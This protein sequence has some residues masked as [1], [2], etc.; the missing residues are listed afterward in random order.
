MT[1]VVN[2]SEDKIQQFVNKLQNKL[3]EHIDDM[4]KLKDKIN[5]LNSVVKELSDVIGR[6]KDIV[7]VRETPAFEES[8][9]I[10]TKN[11]V[12]TFGKKNNQ[13]GAFSWNGVPHKR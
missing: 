11:G 10:N 6:I 9:T 2:K 1:E 8:A 13:S 3:D 12:L 5:E 7:H 4:T